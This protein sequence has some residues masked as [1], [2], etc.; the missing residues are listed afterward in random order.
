MNVKE[1]A[2]SLALSSLWKVSAED[3]S[4]ILLG[5]FLI[6]LVWRDFNFVRVKENLFSFIN[7]MDVY[8]PSRIV[9]RADGSDLIFFS[10]KNGLRLVAEFDPVTKQVAKARMTQDNEIKYAATVM[11]DKVHNGV[12]H[13]TG[14]PALIMRD[15]IME[16]DKIHFEK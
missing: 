6:I 14:D 2:D 4:L 10:T 16:Q 8:F 3:S 12:A 7:R 15:S 1:T 9:K 11:T 13:K 5:R